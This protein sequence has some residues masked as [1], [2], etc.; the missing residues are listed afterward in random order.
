M[1]DLQFMNKR[2]DILGRTFS[3][4][5]RND[6]N[7]TTQ[8]IHPFEQS[9]RYVHVHFD[10]TRTERYQKV[11]GFMRKRRHARQACEI[12]L[13]FDGMKNPEN[14]VDLGF[15]IRRFLKRQ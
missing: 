14:L 15:I 13:A 12:G 5:C 6:I 11:F 2:P 1:R 3:R 10:N 4:I 7:D 8:M 9:G